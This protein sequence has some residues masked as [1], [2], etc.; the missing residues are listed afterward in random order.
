[1]QG[2]NVCNFILL[3]CKSV[4]NLFD[5]NERFTVYCNNISNFANE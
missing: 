3:L 1:M 2:E 4:N 5:G